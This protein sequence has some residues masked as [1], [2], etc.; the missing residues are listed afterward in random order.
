MSIYRDKAR[1][2]Y[3]FEFDVRLDGQRI[4]ARK[5]LPKAWTRAQANA[6]DEKERARLYAQ[7]RNGERPRHTIDDAVALYLEHRCPE[8]KSGENT[9]REIL[10][11]YWAYGGK[12]LEALTEVCRE[13]ARDGR[14]RKEDRDKPLSAATI[15]NRIR[16]LAAACR[17]AWKHH[18]LGDSDPTARITVP[19]V[20][21]E[22]H[23]YASRAEMLQIARAMRVQTGHDN[24]ARDARAVLRIGFYSGMRLAEI[25]RAEPKDD[26][27][28]LGT[29]KNGK[30]RLVPIHPK[31]RCC[32]WI[33]KGE[34]LAKVTVQKQFRMARARVGLDHLHFHDVRHSAASEMIN[35]GVDLYTVGAVLGHADARSTKRYAHLATQTLVAAVGK[36][37][38]KIPH[39]GTKKPPE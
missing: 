16:Y 28:Y 1:G 25:L 39:Q 5:I 17:Y 35:A 36:I 10:L 13:I 23:F 37:G 7:V 27:F 18:G 9:K 8:L 2:R 14:E 31:I 32:L 21:N 34:M 22:R 12:P 38:Q 3:V 15:R 19:A 6:F 26:C 29:T 20:S 24:R 30:P 11:M 4:R 33:Y